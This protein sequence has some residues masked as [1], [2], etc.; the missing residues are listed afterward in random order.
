M[1]NA[2]KIRS[3]MDAEGINGAELARRSGIT[4]SMIS[5]ILNG[6]RNNLKEHTLARLCKGLKCKADDIMDGVE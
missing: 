3:L 6:K 4:E 1:A 5:L 2:K